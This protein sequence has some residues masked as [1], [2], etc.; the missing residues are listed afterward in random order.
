MGLYLLIAGCDYSRIVSYGGILYVASLCPL[1][2]LLF[3]GRAISGAKSWVS[4]PFFNFQP[5]EIAKITTLLVVAGL[6]AR[7]SG[8]TL[9]FRGYLLFGAAIDVDLW[10][11]RMRKDD[12]RLALYRV[13][14]KPEKDNEQSK[15]Q[16]KRQKD[17]AS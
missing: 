15:D 14:A 6:F 3:A 7:R 16:D 4:L 11:V 2:Y 13:L 5:S 12:S 1:V 9:R 10:S 8:D 17:R